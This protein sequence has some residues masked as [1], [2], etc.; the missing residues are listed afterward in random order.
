MDPATLP[1]RDI[2][3][4]EPVGW[5]PPAPG[6]WLLAF[7]LALLFVWI[8]V[9]VRKARRQG[10]ARRHALK[11]LK[12]LEANYDRD[13]NAVALGRGL[14]ILVRRTMLAY[15]PRAD[16][17][18]LAGDA[19]LDWLDD[20]LANPQFRLGAGRALAE[21]PYRDPDSKHDDID[22]NTL[23]YAVRMR[24]ATPVKTAGKRIRA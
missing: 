6:W 7:V 2:R 20:G 1:L 21:L 4:P 12:Q 19:W 8:A 24:L 22:V 5:W 13:G 15:A 17:A 10:R 23:L 16:V 11:Q 14:S 18:G 9:R 3:L